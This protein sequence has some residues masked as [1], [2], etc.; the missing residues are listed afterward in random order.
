MDKVIIFQIVE[1]KGGLFNR[2]NDL[3]LLLYF[4]KLVVTGK[5]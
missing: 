3:L 2:V 4:V 1:F 5:D